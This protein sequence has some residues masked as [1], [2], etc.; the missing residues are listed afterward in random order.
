M[1]YL[2]EIGQPDRGT[3]LGPG[4][5]AFG[6]QAG[7]YFDRSPNWRIRSNIATNWQSG[8][9]GATLTARYVSAVDENC[10]IVRSTANSIGQPEL[11][12]QLCSNPGPNGS[13]QFPIAENQLD[14][15]WYF[16]VQATWD[17]P[18][19]GRITGGIRNLLDEDPP[20]SFSVFANS[21]DPQYEVPG[22]FWYVQYSQKF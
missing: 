19:D 2:G 3:V 11:V 8:D 17:A 21:F 6:N 1:S 5:T 9:W 10:A 18:W 22:R 14:D 7:V 12:N 4:L 20:L 16:D 15:T 13:A